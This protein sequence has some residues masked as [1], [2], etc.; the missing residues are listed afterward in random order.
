VELMSGYRY[1]RGRGERTRESAA[2][3][4]QHREQLAAPAY[5]RRPASADLAPN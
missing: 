5:A 3:D 2:I 1:Y 4:N